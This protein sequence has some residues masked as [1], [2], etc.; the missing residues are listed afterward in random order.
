MKFLAMDHGLEGAKDT[1]K[2]NSLLKK[3]VT[4][5]W[6]LYKEGTIR[7]MYQRSDNPFAV[8]ILECSNLEE[9]RQK[10]GT[11]PFSQAGITAWEI[12]PIQPFAGLEAIIVPETTK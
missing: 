3:D 4:R 1:A 11:I 8:L 7:E 2:V 6:E 10:L 9:A 12:I 5:V